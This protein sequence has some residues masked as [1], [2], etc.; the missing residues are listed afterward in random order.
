MARLRAENEAEEVRLARSDSREETKGAQKPRNSQ[1]IENARLASEELL[2]TDQQMMQ[3][4]GF[5]GFGST[6]HKAVEDNKNSAA[7][8]STSKNKAR[9]YRQYMNRKGGFNRPLDKM[10]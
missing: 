7:A 2:S 10:T 1:K 5:S 8:G 3:M 4:L 9:K 6:K